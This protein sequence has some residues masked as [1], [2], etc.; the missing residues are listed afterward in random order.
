VA[1]LYAAAYV[2]PSGTRHRVQRA[3]HDLFSASPSFETGRV[4]V[5][6]RNILEAVQKHGL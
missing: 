6:Y 3:I 1:L 5:P 4:T 2:L